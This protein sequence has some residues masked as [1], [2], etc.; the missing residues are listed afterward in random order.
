M[1]FISPS[2][3]RAFRP[4]RPPPAP[5]GNQPRPNSSHKVIRPSSASR[6]VRPPS[7]AL[8]QPLRSARAVSH[9]L[10]GLLRS[11]P[12]RGLPRV[13][14]MG[15][16]ALQ[17]CSRLAEGPAVSDATSPHDLAATAPALPGTSCPAMLP[18]CVSR[19]L[20]L[21]ADR[22]R[23]L[24]VSLPPGIDPLLGFLLWGLASTSST[25]FLASPAAVRPRHVSRFEKE[26]LRTQLHEFPRFPGGRPAPSRV[27]I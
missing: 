2:E 4:V 9:D 24:P 1:E 6:S 22:I 23:Q 13:S 18:R 16:P 19:V 15:F 25:S 26:Q 11:D 3:L 5:Q 8:P 7:A 27:P 12:P 21:R 10:D 20:L 14:L 17:G